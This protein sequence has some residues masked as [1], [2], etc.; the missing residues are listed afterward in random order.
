MMGQPTK[1]ELN[2]FFTEACGV[3][4]ISNNFTFLIFGVKDTMI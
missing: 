3:N 2:I 1:T 4:G